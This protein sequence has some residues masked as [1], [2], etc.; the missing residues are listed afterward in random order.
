MRRM[1]E[2]LYDMDKTL[3][4][5]YLEMA[6]VFWWWNDGAYDSN[7]RFLAP[8]VLCK[9]IRMSSSFEN[10]P[11]INHHLMNN[12]FNG[13]LT[14]GV[15]R[16]SIAPRTSKLM[17]VFPKGRQKVIW[18]CSPGSELLYR[19]YS[20]ACHFV[21]VLLWESRAIG[22]SLWYGYLSIIWAK[23]FLGIFDA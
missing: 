1:I 17:E 15:D 7:L 6:S 5:C 18:D 23:C 14:T 9:W 13:Y 4:W 16:T 11:Q 3:Y 8:P 2:L 10:L 12:N 21:N 20:D 22:G 19:W